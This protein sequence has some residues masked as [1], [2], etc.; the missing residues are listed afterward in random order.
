MDI[1]VDGEYSNNLRF[2]D[3]IVRL[4]GSV[5]QLQDIQ[6]SLDTRSNEI[7]LKTYMKQG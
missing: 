3:D 7:E 1:K 2:V 5:K 4:S 6:M